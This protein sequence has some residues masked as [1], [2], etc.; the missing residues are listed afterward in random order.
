[1]PGV[2]GGSGGRLA[3]LLAYY[4]VLRLR[5]DVRLCLKGSA[6]YAAGRCYGSMAFDATSHCDQTFTPPP[7]PIQHALTLWL[8]MLQPCMA[9]A[10][11]ATTVNLIDP[12]RDL[13][14]QWLAL[15]LRVRLRHLQD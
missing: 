13:P 15:S 7:S 2:P 14:L 6:P 5:D 11:I 4:A 12:Q 1:M 10:P 9:S 8:S 3:Q